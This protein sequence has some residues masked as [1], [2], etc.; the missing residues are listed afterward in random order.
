[1]APAPA[2]G[3]DRIFRANLLY[4]T[5]V[6]LLVTVGAAAQ[7]WRIWPGLM[8][9]EALAILWPAWRFARRTG[10]PAE[11]LRLRRVGAAAVAAG[12]LIGI[13]AFPVAV[14]VSAIWEK[15]LG[16][17]LPFP[18]ADQPQGA[19]ATAVY[20]LAL[21][22][23]A[24]VCEET[25]FHGYILRACEA[26]G[27][28]PRRAI[29]FVA[30]LFTAWHLSPARA[31]GV[32]VAALLLTYVAWRTGSIWPAVGGHVGANGTAAALLL[33][34]AKLPGEGLGVIGLLLLACACAT[35]A[36]ALCAWGLP[37]WRPPR[38]ASGASQASP[39]R[40]LPLAIAAVP[41]AAV[42]VVEMTVGRFG[43]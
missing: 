20:L 13:C 2:P 29:L 14:T 36:T 8:I 31:P 39:F 17:H 24:P 21:V 22:V 7:A 30:A 18:E 23:M 34:R 26:E 9:T 12:V 42:G 15:A 28:P 5:T 35:V 4:L 37:R 41:I 1:M 25:V 38:P 40:Y 32:S 27:W 43:R 6:A 19:S 33:L 16:Y 11:A 3:A 10:S